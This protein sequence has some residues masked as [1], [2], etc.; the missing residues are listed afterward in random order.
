MLS[1]HIDL[2]TIAV[3]AHQ[4]RLRAEAKAARQGQGHLRS[5]IGHWLVRLGEAIGG[6][7]APRAGTVLSTPVA[8]A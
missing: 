7:P 8:L 3:A 5:V 4:E 1:D 6:A 2:A